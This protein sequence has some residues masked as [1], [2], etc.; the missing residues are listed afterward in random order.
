MIASCACLLFVIGSLIGYLA[1]RKSAGVGIPALRQLTF[2]SRIVVPIPTKYAEQFPSMVTDG[3]HLFATAIRAGHS[4]LVQTSVNGG[5][6]QEV[7]LP[8]EISAPTLGDISPDYSRLLLVS[9]SPYGV[10]M[11]L[12]VVPI[13]GSSARLL[14]GVLGHDATWMP[15]GSD[16]LYAANNELRILHP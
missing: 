1:A 9:H 7:V 11:P 10:E 3:V 6:L 15:N 5:E 8:D 14:S 16:I 4:T 2:D 12:W 13:G